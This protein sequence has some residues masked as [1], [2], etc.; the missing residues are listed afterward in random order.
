M[1]RK[2]KYPTPEEARA[3][4]ESGVEAAREKYVMRAK[5]GADDFELWFAGF[6]SKVYPLIATLPDPEGLT[7]E[8]RYLKRGAPVGKTIHTLSLAYRKAK[9]E[10]VA[11]IA[12]ETAA[13]VLV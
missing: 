9:R 11:K 10:R 12:A 4:F 3:R 5:E 1:A 6:A 8:E 7:I 13:K 2:P